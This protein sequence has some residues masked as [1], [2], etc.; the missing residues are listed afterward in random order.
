MKRKILGAM[1]AV[2]LVVGVTIRGT[3]PSPQGLS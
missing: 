3:R 1:L 2:A